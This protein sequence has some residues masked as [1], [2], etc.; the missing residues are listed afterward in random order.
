MKFYKI[1]LGLLFIHLS[2]WGQIEVTL[3]VERMVLQRNKNNQADIH[4]GGNVSSTFDKI[5][6][7]LVTLGKDGKPLEPTV[8]SNWSTI[9]TNQKTGTFLGKLTNQPA[10]WYHLQVRGMRGDSLI[11][12][13]STVKMGIGEVFLIAGQSN[14]QGDPPI[15]DPTLYDAEDDRVNCIN[16]QDFGIDKPFKYPTFSRITKTSVVGPTGNSSW[17]WPTL[18]DEISKNWNVPV[19]FLN[20]AIGG[21]GVF[22]WRAS[23]K[24][25]FEPT[26][27]N[28]VAGFPYIH[29][30]RTLNYYCSFT[31]VRAVLWHQGEV[32]TGIF[33]YGNGTDPSVYTSNLRQVIEISRRDFGK[34]VSWV[35]ARA[36]MVN[37]NTSWRVIR[38]QEMVNEIANFNTFAGPYTDRIQPNAWERDGGVHFLK[39]GIR[40][41]GKAWFNSINNNTFLNN[42]IPHAASE[43]LKS[44]IGT[45][46]VDLSTIIQMPD[47]LYN[48]E[49]YNKQMQR[50][51]NN[52]NLSTNNEGPFYPY[53]RES[54][55]GNYIVSPAVSYKPAQLNLS[56]DGPLNNCEGTTL[57]V[58]PGSF[59]VNYVW[60]DGQNYLKYPITKNGTYNIKVSTTDVYGCT[61]S[62]LATYTAKFN[63]IPSKA[64][65]TTNVSPVLCEGSSVQLSSSNDAILKRLWSNGSTSNNITLNTAQTITLKV[66]DANNCAS[67]VSD[68]VKIVVNPNP[69]KPEIQAGGPLLFCTNEKV[70]LATALLPNQPFTESKY[71]WYNNGVLVNDLKGKFVGVSLPGNYQAKI[72]NQF[73][74]PS[75]LTDALKVENHPLPPTPTVSILGNTRFCGG[76]A[77]ELVA[78]TSYPNTLV[79]S[80]NSNANYSNSLKITVQSQKDTR[81]NYTDTFSALIRDERGCKSLGSNPVTVDVRA[82]PTKAFISKIG[83]FKLEANTVFFGVDGQ[84][85]DWFLNGNKLNNIGNGNGVKIDQN[86]IY[87]TIS[88]INYKFNDGP[89]LV[90]QSEVSNSY[91]FYEDYNNFFTVYPNPVKHT[92]TL[93]VDIRQPVANAN[94]LI[95]NLKGQ[96]IFSEKLLNFDS[97]KTLNLKNWDLPEGNYKVVLR[98]GDKFYYKNLIVNH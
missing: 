41:L 67:P 46:G 76:G 40:D 15:A 43:P 98:V 84:Q 96:L 32:D 60:Q 26:V 28:S 17:C 69:S 39:E 72:F 13:V 58:L 53:M 83:T 90:C 80:N 31:G 23:A 94:F 38:G 75:P 86:G 82:N 45:C 34:N 33:E 88:K 81:T 50:Q 59:N 29:L 25:E 36:S 66:V 56:L 11:G 55:T 78:N 3:P 91:N 19:A 79:W 18:G 21:T 4:I 71:E 20:C 37:G 64:L 47:G 61:A 5:E 8:A 9:V 22:V 42:S 74:C 65:I 77:V 49:W 12:Q 44:Q 97:E 70:T 89:D 92:E 62:A 6:A 95:Y 51:S 14:A 1:L 85:Y 54:N 24:R 57:N 73:N 30:Q 35:I 10:G 87:T 16:E 93:K 68:P 63:P 27:I 7:R 52:L 2:V 48:Y